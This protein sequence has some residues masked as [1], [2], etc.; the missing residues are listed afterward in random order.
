[1][2]NFPQR[3]SLYKQ[4]TSLVVVYPSI[5]PFSRRNSCEFQSDDDMESNFS[6]QSKVIFMKISK[7][8]VSPPTFIHYSQTAGSY[9]HTDEGYDDDDDD[10]YCKELPI[11]SAS[12]FLPLTDAALD[13]E[14]AAV[15]I[16]SV[17]RGYQCRKQQKAGA[18]KVSHRVLAGLAHIND[19]IH[20]RNYNQLQKKLDKETAMRMAFEKTMEDMTVLMDHQHSVLHE[21]LEQEVNMRQTY[22]RKMDQTIAQIQPLEARL[23]HE[24]KARADMESMMSRIIDQLQDLRVQVKEQAEQKQAL[25]LKLDDANAELRKLKTTTRPGSRL[26]TKKS[27]ETISRKTTA[28]STPAR[29]VQSRASVRST[30][31]PSRTSVRSTATPTKTPVRST[32]TPSRTSVRSTASPSIKGTVFR[33]QTT[34]VSSTKR[35]SPSRT[36]KK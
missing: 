15:K 22:E 5:H 26:S 13:R 24:A 32:A 19:S 31:T 30:T 25:Q 33:Q 17:W 20:R 18:L 3:I 28:S 9:I 2:V 6:S 36:L 11:E 29:D 8:H 21:R 16:Q 7:S 23:R 27:A 1:M 35:V 14:A 10:D 12:F 34:T 4:L